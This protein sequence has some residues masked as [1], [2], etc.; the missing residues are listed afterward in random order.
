MDLYAAMTQGTGSVVSGCDL[1]VSSVWTQSGRP[2]AMCL[3]SDWGVLQLAFVPPAPRTSSDCLPE[4]P[5]RPRS[6]ALIRHL[7]GIF[8]ERLTVELDSGSD[9]PSASE[10]LAAARREYGGLRRECT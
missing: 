4:G 1:S 5:R 8:I 9:M 10:V 6:R 3:T 2:S 7:V